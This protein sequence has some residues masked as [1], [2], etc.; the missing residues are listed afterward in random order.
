M[1]EYIYKSIGE[2]QLKLKVYFPENWT[3]EDRRSAIIFYFGGGWRGGKIDQF[4][5]QCEYLASLGMV[6]V[7]PEYRVKSKHGTTPFQA[8]EDA[9]DALRW[10]FD[11]SEDLGIDRN[12]IAVGGGSAGAHLAACTAILRNHLRGS[13]EIWKIPKAL[14]LFNPVTNTTEIGYGSNIIGDRA[15][16][17][18]PVHHILPG[19]PPTIIFHGTADLTVPFKNSEDFCELMK[20]NGNECELIQYEGQAHGFFNMREGQ[21]KFYRDTIERTEQFLRRH[22]FITCS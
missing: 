7:T 11:H 12:R 21:E 3:R 9:G 20:K 8:V 13:E 2:I 16:D 19:L 10:V 22:G 14:V 1:T 6:A 4:Q 5:P 18:S 15:K 17:L